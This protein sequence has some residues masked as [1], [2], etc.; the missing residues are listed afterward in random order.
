[1]LPHRSNYGRSIWEIDME[2]I[3][4]QLTRS[5]PMPFDIYLMSSHW[6]RFPYLDVLR[7]ELRDHRRWRSFTVLDSEPTA[8]GL[9]GIF[10]SL[11]QKTLPHLERLNIISYPR[12]YNPWPNPDV[13]FFRLDC[14]KL[15]HVTFEYTV[16]DLIGIPWCQIEEL[17]LRR[18]PELPLSLA[19]LS[20][21]RILKLEE[22][23]FSE[24]ANEGQAILP[25]LEVLDITCICPDFLFPLI[26]TPALHTIN[27][28]SLSSRSIESP[29]PFRQLIL[30]S[31]CAILSFSIDSAPDV[32]L[33]FDLLAEMPELKHL[34]TNVYFLEQNGGGYERSELFSVRMK[35]RLSERGGPFRYCPRLARLVLNDVGDPE[36]T[37]LWAILSMA[38]ERVVRR[39][40]GDG[41]GGD[42]GLEEVVLNEVDSKLRPS[43]L[44]SGDASGSRFWHEVER[45]RRLGMIVKVKFTSY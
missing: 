33:L 6:K 34:E 20:N 40:T 35:E 37:D 11:G 24:T 3:Q 13:N 4:L 2:L 10:P 21:L 17:T 36:K 16:P 44:I 38:E 27:F 8:G 30:R 42:M 23:E 29:E 28:D 14:P 43:R 12:R 31:R 45:L 7:T 9:L 5:N 25:R 1:M 18:I 26:T 19:V 41:L 15:R 39:G 22:T 32:V